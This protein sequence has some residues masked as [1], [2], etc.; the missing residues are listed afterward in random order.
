MKSWD[1]Q[2][3]EPTNQNSLKFPKLL[4]QQIRKCYYETLETSVINNPMSP[5]SLDTG[6]IATEE[7]LQLDNDNSF[8][9]L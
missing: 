7:K 6:D 8:E 3:T 1:T 5:T 2:T 4:I 9:I